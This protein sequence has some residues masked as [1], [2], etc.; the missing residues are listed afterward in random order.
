MFIYFQASAQ[1]DST[2]T[3]SGLE[4]RFFATARLLKSKSF[5]V[6]LYAGIIAR[7]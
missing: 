3:A 1:Y 6:V 5:W 4:A 2:T 7:V